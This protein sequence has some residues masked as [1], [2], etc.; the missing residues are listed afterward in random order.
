MARDRSGRVAVVLGGTQGIGKELVKSLVAQ[1]STVYLSGRTM[2]SA[3]RAVGDV[4]GDTH[5]LAID[6]SE[7]ATLGAALA[8]VPRVDDL[9]IG[10][11]ERDANSIKE[12]SVERA[13]RLVTLKLVGYTEAIHQLLDRFGPEASVVLFGGLALE[14][15]YPGSTT[16]STVNGGVVGMVHSLSCELAPVRVN[17][18]HPGIVGDSPYWEDK[19]NSGIVSRTPLG[20][21]VTMGEIVDAVEFLLDNQGVNGVNLAVDGGWLRK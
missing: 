12:Y 16:V 4:G 9:V 2:E 8:G 5:P 20:R 17:A 3:R 14:R 18:V 13:L 21:L 1:G 6:L 11:I 19:D 7:P 15:P 10:A